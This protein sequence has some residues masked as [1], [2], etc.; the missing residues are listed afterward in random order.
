MPAS[1]VETNLDRDYGSLK[2]LAEAATPSPWC[3]TGDDSSEAFGYEIAQDIWEPN[4]DHGEDFIG[5]IVVDVR[6]DS[7]DAEHP[8][9]VLLRADAD[10]IAAACP[11]TVI[12]LINDR[13]HAREMLAKWEELTRGHADINRS[14]LND[15]A[16]LKADNETLTGALLGILEGDVG[17]WMLDKLSAG[18]GAE[19]IDGQKWLAALNLL[20]VPETLQ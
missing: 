9:G 2:A 13:N 3:V 20:T 1:E 17:K 16:Q 7:E 15:V 19:T 14:L 12:G 5:N 6:S 11:S 8:V 10:F 18:Q 4:A